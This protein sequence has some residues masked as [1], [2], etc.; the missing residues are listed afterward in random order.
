MIKLDLLPSIS[1]YT[2]QYF[3]KDD[4]DN[5][6]CSDE[7]LNLQQMSTK[8][9]YDFEVHST[10]ESFTSDCYNSFSNIQTPKIGITEQ[11]CNEFSLFS[12]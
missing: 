11:N 5:K 10:N 2:T 4:F 8:P 9:D 7:K 12:Q 6:L 3:A 1:N